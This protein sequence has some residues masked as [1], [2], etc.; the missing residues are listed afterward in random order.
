M[1]EHAGAIVAVNPVG[2]ARR[3][4]HARGA[5]THQADEAVSARSV[6]AAE[7]NCRG[8]VR[9]FRAETFSFEHFAPAEPSRLGGRR[10][11]YPLAG[12]LAVNPGAGDKDE[13]P[14]G[15]TALLQRLQNIS[16]AANVCA[17]VSGLV[18]PV[19]GGR[20]KRIVRFRQRA[21][22]G[23]IGQ[24]RGQ[25]IQRLRQCS[26][27][28]AKRVHPVPVLDQPETQGDADVAAARDENIRHIGFCLPPDRES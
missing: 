14:N 26:H 2:V 3:L 13:S 25:R 22:R 18:T 4:L 12:V 28:A 5:F 23:R 17:L 21:Q 7:T 1:A 11:V 9:A 19:G 24:I 16:H 6:N 20:I 8:G 15:A 27:I 10:L